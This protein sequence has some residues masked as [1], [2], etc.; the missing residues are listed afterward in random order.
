MEWMSLMSFWSNILAVPTVQF[1]MFSD[2]R[3]WNFAILVA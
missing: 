3:T 1:L 2:G